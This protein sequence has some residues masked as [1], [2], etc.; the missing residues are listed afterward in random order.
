MQHLRRALIISLLCLGA[1]AGPDPQPPTAPGAAIDWPQPVGEVALEVV[2]AV[3]QPE[4]DVSLVVFDAGLA[5][6][7]RPTPGLFPAI[8]RHETRLL[9]VRLRQVLQASGA[10]GAVRV[11]PEARSSAH[12]QVQGRILHSDGERL[13]LALRVEDARGEVWLDATYHDETSPA[14]YPVTD[15]TDP[16]QDVYHRI[17]NDLL[18]ARQA[19]DTERLRRLPAVATLRYAAELLPG[20]FAAFLERDGQ[21][22]WQLR[23]L[24]A[25]YDPMLARVALIREREYLF[26]DTVDEQYLDLARALQPAYDLWRQFTREQSHYRADYRERLADRQRAGPPGSYAAME[27]SYNA[28]RWSRIQEQD[29]EELARGFDNEVRPTVLSVD[30]QVY[31]LSG[32]LAGQYA[33]WRDIL[34]QILALE[35][36]LPEETATRE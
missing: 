11:Q 17:A 21:G 16:F 27:Q 36:G 3:P 10:W 34:R 25:E 4:L 30:G 31:R 19:R 1:C 24:P 26:V 6:D 22:H 35:M 18:A 29:L 7:S 33:E 15:G 12:L 9:P 14:D 32:S 20:A 28:F 2:A 13:V 8:R 23:R 5:K